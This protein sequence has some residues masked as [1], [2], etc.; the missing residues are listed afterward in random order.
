MSTLA[1]PPVFRLADEDGNRL[2]FVSDG[3]AVAYVFVLE[4]H[5]MRVMVLPDGKIKHSKSWAI[6]I[7]RDDVPASGRDRFDLSGFRL[8]DFAIDDTQD[9]K[10]VVETAWLRLTIGL[11]GFLC[12]WESYDDTADGLVEVL[13]DR[14]TQAYN[15]GWWDDRVHHYL[16][17]EPGEMY[18]GLGERSGA[19]DRAGRRFRMNNVDAMGYDAKTSD[20]LY[21]HIPYYITRKPNG[22]TVGLFYDTLSDC[23]FDMGCERSNYHGLFRSF[24]AD[25]GDLDYYVIGHDIQGI[26][27]GFTWLTGSPAFL[28]KW[29]LGYSGS[30]MSYTD[31]PDAQ[32]AMMEFIAKCK[33]HDILCDSFH[34]SSGY[35][36]IGDKRYVFHWNRD[37]FPD[38]AAF[39][40][41][42]AEKGVRLI[43]NIK[44]ALLHDH[45]LFAEARDKGLLITDG[46]GAPEWVQFWGAHGAY[47]DFTNPKTLAWWKEK[48]TM[49]LLVPGMAGTWNDN[50]EFEIVSPCA[51]AKIGPAIETKPLQTMLMMRASREAQLARAPDKRPFLVSRSGAAGMQ[52]YVQTWSGDNYTSWE[53]LKWNI[54]MGL[55][56]AL[57]GVSNTGH[58]V[59]GFDGPKPDAELF[60]RWV[61]FG[62]FMPRFSIHSWNTDRSANEPWM[63]PGVTPVVRDLI[64]LRYRL[65]PYLY[66]L[67]HRYATLYEPIIRP[68]F[69]D[70]PDDPRCFEDSDDMLLGPSLLV[71]AVVEKGAATRKVYL[72]AGETWFDWWTGEI[73]EG[74]QTVTRPAPI[75]RP[76]LFARAG[77]VIALNIAEQHFG[78]RADTR[79]FAVFPVAEGAFSDDIY[80]D[81]GESLDPAAIIWRVAV[82]CTRDEIAIAVTAG[83]A[84]ADAPIILPATETRR[85]T[86]TGG[87]RVD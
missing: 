68:A 18:F 37:K 42:Y 12:T 25:H 32:A 73:F 78:S 4:K 77:S 40:R 53:T 58:D 1:N 56:L 43:P 55:G 59:G 34:L 45:P 27:A 67:S 16:V 49:S 61:G 80:D 71:V 76:P 52:R 82:T 11:R 44:P 50:N 10:I 21:K 66:D 39:V 19:V 57:S 84:P 7:G 13:K 87:R 33:E 62:I 35:T 5:I 23:T 36:S 47:L 69:H 51:Q 8:P 26:V 30:T 65:L 24:V 9:G 20:P 83:D 63:H 79:G 60:A 54:R 6:A 38:P 28:P 2:T 15:F 3:P 81:D 70:F 14:P 41:S 46:D 64:K 74:G 72:P 31:R 86:V 85:V 75:D 48:V 17:R 29:A 22:A